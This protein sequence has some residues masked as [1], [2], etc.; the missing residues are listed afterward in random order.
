MA[1][2]VTSTQ[3]LR[4]LVCGN[5][6]CDNIIGQFGHAFCVASEYNF[7]CVE[8]ESIKKEKFKNE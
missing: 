1:F 3:D 8:K 2:V 7:L 6:R 5:S 4:V